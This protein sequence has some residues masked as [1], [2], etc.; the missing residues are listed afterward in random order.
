[1]NPRGRYA[2]FRT[3]GPC[4]RATNMLLAGLAEQREA[5]LSVLCHGEPAPLELVRRKLE[6]GDRLGAVPESSVAAPLPRD[7]EAQQKRLPLKPTT[8]A[9]RHDLDLR[10]G[11]G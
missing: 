7:L 3:A 11:S 1:M 9:K 2:A 10:E 5:M 6:V 4:A 8:E